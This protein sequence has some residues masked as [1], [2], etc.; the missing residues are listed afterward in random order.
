M[1]K[2]QAKQAMRHIPWG[3]PIP[4]DVLDVMERVTQRQAIRVDMTD[5]ERAA[6]RLYLRQQMGAA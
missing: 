1:T 6:R 3:K 5:G 2:R 4:P